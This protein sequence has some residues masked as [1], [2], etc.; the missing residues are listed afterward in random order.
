METIRKWYCSCR[1]KPQELF[2]ANPLEE[3]MGEPTCSRCGASP[4][5]DPKKTISFKD[6]RGGQEL[7]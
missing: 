6:F 1:G 3:E 4:S 5:S 2:F 7:A